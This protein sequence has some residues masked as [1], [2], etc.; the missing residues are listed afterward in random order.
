[1]DSQ[2]RVILA[3]IPHWEERK[4]NVANLQF[5]YPATFGNIVAK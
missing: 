2:E 1:M 5:T 3:I 4:R